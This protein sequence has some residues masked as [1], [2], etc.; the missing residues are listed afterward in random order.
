M[1]GNVGI[2]A[3]VRVVKIGDTFLMIAVGKGLIERGERCHGCDFS[4]RT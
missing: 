1:P 2:V 4:I 3:H